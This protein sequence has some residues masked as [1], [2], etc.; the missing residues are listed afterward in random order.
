MSEAIA[1]EIVNKH[2]CVTAKESEAVK[3]VV[4]KNNHLRQSE[5][6]NR[7]QLVMSFNPQISRDSDNEWCCV[8]GYDHD[9]GLQAHGS[10]ALDAVLKMFNKLT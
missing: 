9:N 5:I 7:V 3:P 10:S 4:I 2:D 1:E 8:I 6:N